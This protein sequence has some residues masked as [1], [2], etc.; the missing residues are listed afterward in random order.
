MRDPHSLSRRALRSWG[1]RSSGADIPPRAADCIPSQSIVSCTRG[2]LPC[3]S[4]SASGAAWWCSGRGKLASREAS[5][6]YAALPLRAAGTH[7][8][9]RLDRRTEARVEPRGLRHRRS[10]PRISTSPAADGCGGLLYCSNTSAAYCGA[11]LVP[12][13]TVR[14]SPGRQ[15]ASLRSCSILGLR[16]GNV[17]ACAERRTKKRIP[18]TSM[19]STTPSLM[20]AHCLQMR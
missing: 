20:T 3:T 16:L 12:S 2:Y 6:R 19:R 17:A 1:F 4:G 13:T 18:Q 11:R 14:P 15:G 7:G 5:E 9:R 10:D 8:A